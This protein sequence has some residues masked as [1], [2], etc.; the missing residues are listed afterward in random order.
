M[1]TAVRKAIILGILTVSSSPV[2]L[3]A[4]EGEVKEFRGDFQTGLYVKC[5]EAYAMAPM[6]M[7][8]NRP[9]VIKAADDKV[10]DKILKDIC[11]NGDD[12]KNAPALG[13]AMAKQQMFPSSPYAEAL[14]IAVFPDDSITVGKELKSTARFKHGPLTKLSQVIEKYGK[15]QELERWTAKDFQSWIGL[16]ATVHWWGAVGIA[17]TQD[18]A[19][20]H[21]LI[22][23][24]EDVLDSKK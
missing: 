19:I 16:N 9:P 2:L 13:R 24:K 17:A 22:R 21:V 12:L 11:N 7:D 10:S 1:K 8:K 23:E 14:H 3:G 15:A 5:G 6:F 4:S 20:T 18:G